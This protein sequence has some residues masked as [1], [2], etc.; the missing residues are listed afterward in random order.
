MASETYMDWLQQQEESEQYHTLYYKAATVES[1]MIKKSCAFIQNEYMK[2]SLIL[3]QKR[4]YC[5]MVFSFLPKK[6]AFK[7]MQFCVCL[8]KMF[9]PLKGSYVLFIKKTNQHTAFNFIGFLIQTTI[10]QNYLLTQVTYLIGHYNRF[11]QNER[12]LRNF[13]WQFYLWCFLFYHKMYTLF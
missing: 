7:K 13:S 1:S 10:I 5:L 11:S 3:Q 8:L 6:C 2:V 12:F 4:V 9:R